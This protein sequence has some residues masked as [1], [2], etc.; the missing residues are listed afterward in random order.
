MASPQSTHEVQ[1]AVEGADLASVGLDGRQTVTFC[2]EPFAIAD[3]VADFALWKYARVL[4]DDVDGV[5]RLAAQHVLLQECIAPDEWARFERHA[6]AKKAD[7]AELVGVVNQV[8]EMLAARPT[9]RPNDSST[10]PQPTPPN[11]KGSSSTGDIPSP[12]GGSA[13]TPPGR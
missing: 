6:L 12:G 5:Q 11:S 7:G 8:M 2:G 3:E 13:G 9:R 10:G 1:A 4:D